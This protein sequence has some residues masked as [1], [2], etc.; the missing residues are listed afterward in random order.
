MQQIKHWAGIKKWVGA[1]AFLLVFAVFFSIINPMFIP[2]EESRVEKAAFFYQPEETM[3]VIYIGSSSMLRAVTPLEIWRDYGITGYSLATVMQGPAVTLAYL[4]DMFQTQSPQ[5]VVLGCEWLFLDYDYAA[6]ESDLRMALDR[7]PNSL[8][9]LELAQSIVQ[10]DSSQS[11]LSYLFPML[12]YHS[13][14]TEIETYESVDVT[15]TQQMGF[16][17]LCYSKA[18]TIPETHL[19]PSGETPV[20][21]ESSLQYYR[22]A[23]ELCQENGAQVLLV[24]LPHMPWSTEEAQAQQEFAD[25]MGIPFLDFNQTEYWEAASLDVETDFYDAGHLSSTGA[26]KVSHFLGQYLQEEYD[27]ADKRSDP[28]FASWNET[29]E[30]YSQKYAFCLHVD[31]DDI[32]LFYEVG[33]ASSYIDSNQLQPDDF[34]Y[35]WTLYRDGAQI[36]RLENSSSN[37]FT[38]Q[39]DGSGTYIAWCSVYQNGELVSTL[40]SVEYQIA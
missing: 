14:W 17:G 40:N 18:F 26:S 19:A 13:R 20:F 22:E 8:A 36:E 6:R 29:L 27:I 37:Q 7:M 9:K 34:T 4:K 3:D 12:R 30:E 16:G 5:V 2:E 21:S 28:A 33:I 11:F 38:P 15:Q 32:T 10:Q 39:V 1:V 23:I 31:S 24:K 25:E 35:T